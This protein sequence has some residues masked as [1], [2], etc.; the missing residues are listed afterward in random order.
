[1][2]KTYLALALLITGFLLAGNAYGEDEVY[3]C[4]ETDSNGFI[5]DEKS[6]SYQR[7]GFVGDKFKI[8][9]DIASNRIELA[10]EKGN[11]EIYTCTAPYDPRWMSC[12]SKH[13]HF[14]FNTE[15]G[16][17]VNFRGLG[18]MALDGDSITVAYGKCDKF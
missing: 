10:P 5:Y 16:R 8:K 15:N 9:P 11:K 2:K 17:F 3:Y 12:T 18:Y 14:N 1:M 7:S 6:G 13:Y 4:V